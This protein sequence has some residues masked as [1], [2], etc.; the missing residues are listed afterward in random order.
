MDLVNEVSANKDQ[1]ETWFNH[2][3][4]LFC[5]YNATTP[6]PK[7]LISIAEEA[8]QNHWFNPSASYSSA[9]SESRI[10]EKIRN[11]VARLCSTNSNSVVIC[12]SST[13]AINQAI[14]SLS[15]NLGVEGILVI[16]DSEHSAVKNAANHWFA[17]RVH[18]IPILALAKGDTASISKFRNQNQ[19]IAC[20]FQAANN[21]TGLLVPIGKI[22][23]NLG[24]EVLIIADASQ[25][26]GKTENFLSELAAA[27]G[28]V[29][30]PHKFYG[31]KGIGFLVWKN[32]LGKLSPL[33]FGGG[34]EGGARSGT[35]NTPNLFIAGKWLETLPP[36]VDG[37]ESIDMFRS[38]FEAE[39]LNNY[40]SA[41]IICSEFSRMK[42]TSTIFFPDV[43]GDSL[44]AAL[45]SI[46]ISAST[47]SACRAG[48]QEPS[49]SYLSS[50][51]SWDEAR[52][53]VRFSFG[54]G[55]LATSPTDLGKN[56]CGAVFRLRGA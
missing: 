25:L 14:Y 15:K 56:V 10:I 50:G 6:L 22:K 21:E 32:T 42:N 4:A 30:S 1:I 11:K 12:S 36:L 40:K 49:K 27:D 2:V 29:L 9:E 5:D 28:L 35:E 37:F 41:K 18:E 52:C 51:L 47:G 26:I 13:E 33:I 7:P 23:K 39:V 31:P 20:F 43:L 16:S 45:D 19:K 55:N 38:S 24:N 53:V 46:G 54:Y 8:Y 3:S 44:L 48:T 17:G 34:Q